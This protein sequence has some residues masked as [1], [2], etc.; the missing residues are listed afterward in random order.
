MCLTSWD[1]RQRRT[2]TLWSSSSS[3][4]ISINHFYV[5]LCVDE[6]TRC[7]LVMWLTL[8]MTLPGSENSL[9]I[10][11]CCR[12]TMAWPALTNLAPADVSLHTHTR[13]HTQWTHKKCC[14]NQPLDGARTPEIN[15][16]QLSL[17]FWSEIMFINISR[18]HVRTEKRNLVFLYLK[19][20][21][22]NVCASSLSVSRPFHCSVDVGVDLSMVLSA[23]GVLSLQ[24]LCTLC[25]RVSVTSLVFPRT[26]RVHEAKAWTSSAHN[27]TLVWHH[28]TGEVSL[29]PELLQVVSFSFL[30][31]GGTKII[32]SGGLV[33]IWS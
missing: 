15:P 3:S 29:H 33:L 21:F 8:W 30:L 12:D 26:F 7:P 22:P 6:M 23:T 5:F 17:V 19:F 1:C 24:S 14:C 18:K 31:K 32:S 2:L 20:N 13:A 16:L 9:E 28:V 27:C 4:I 11:L 25:V 10:I